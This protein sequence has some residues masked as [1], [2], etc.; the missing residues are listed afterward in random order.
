MLFASRGK[1][2]GD[3]EEE[4]RKGQEERDKENS[5]FVTWAHQRPVDQK[6]GNGTPLYL[7]ISLSVSLNWEEYCFQDTLIREGGTSRW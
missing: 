7:F 1:G 3:G 6:R 2:G 5:G 4:E